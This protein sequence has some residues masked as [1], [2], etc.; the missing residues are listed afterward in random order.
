M[1]AVI[2]NINSPP[3]SLLL[4]PENHY[5]PGFLEYFY[6]S[7]EEPFCHKYL[8]KIFYQMKIFSTFVKNFSIVWVFITTNTNFE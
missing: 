3:I 8:K 4:Y 1:T 6:C 2:N 7:P 5:Q